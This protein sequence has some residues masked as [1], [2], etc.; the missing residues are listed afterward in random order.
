MSRLREKHDRLDVFGENELW[1]RLTVEEEVKL[2]VGMRLHD[3]AKRLA[4]HPSYAFELVFQ[5]Q[6][7]IYRYLHLVIFC[8][9][10][11]F[12]DWLSN[13]RSQKLTIHAGDVRHGDAFRAFSLAGVGV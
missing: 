6:P 9:C 8:K 13:F 5:Q 11:L 10:T 7:G 4:G 3:T 12:F 1:V 2:V